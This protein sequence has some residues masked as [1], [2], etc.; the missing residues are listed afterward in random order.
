MKSHKRL[1]LLALA[2]LGLS[3]QVVLAN[4]TS[5]STTAPMT[6]STSSSMNTSTSN[7]QAS[8]ELRRAQLVQV[9]KKANLLFL[10]K[11]NLIN[12]YRLAG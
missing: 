5:H 4:D 2:I 7:A 1:T 6:S 8:T 9:S 3:S 11:P 12:L 10:G